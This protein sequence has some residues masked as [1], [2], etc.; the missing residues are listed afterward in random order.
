M[1]SLIAANSPALTRLL[2]VASIF[3]GPEFEGV[4]DALRHNTR[5]ED[6]TIYHAFHDLGQDFCRRALLPAVRANTGLRRL[7]FVA[8]EGSGPLPTAAVEAME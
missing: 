8:I 1:R 7:S 2:F 5:L 6:L 4:L 3:P